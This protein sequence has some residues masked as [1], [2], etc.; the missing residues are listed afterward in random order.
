MSVVCGAVLGY[1]RSGCS[2]AELG[3]VT[4]VRV[5]VFSRVVRGGWA[6]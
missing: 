1:E 5:R 6:R 4:G 3:L 2:R